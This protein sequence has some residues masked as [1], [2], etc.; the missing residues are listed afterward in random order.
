LRLTFQ[1]SA[2]GWDVSGQLDQGTAATGSVTFDG[3]GKLTGGGTL[4]VGGIA[5]DLSQLTGYASLDTASI[6]SQNGAAAGALQGY[7]IAKDG[8]LVGTFSNGASLAIGRIALAT[9]ANP[10]GLEKT[11]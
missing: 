8:T 5:V 9:F 7:S 10:A 6:A 11:G 3:T 4:N 1:R 2:G